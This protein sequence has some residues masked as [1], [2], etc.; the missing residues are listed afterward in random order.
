MSKRKE[1]NPRRAL[2]LTAQSPEL[3]G[4]SAETLED[5]VYQLD[6]KSVRND[7]RKFFEN[8]EISTPAD[9][10]WIGAA[11][12]KTIALSYETIT[13]PARA[14]ELIQK[15][16]QLLMVCKEKELTLELPGKLEAEVNERFDKLFTALQSSVT[17]EQWTIIVQKLGI[18]EETQ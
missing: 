7:L 6:D 17:P 18:T 9:Y 11:L 4:P 16:L 3:M 5:R 2:P 8:I 12:K 14:V 13:N 15:A 10:Q 1:F